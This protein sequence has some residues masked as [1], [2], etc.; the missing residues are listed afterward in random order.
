MV[1]GSSRTLRCSPN[2]DFCR[3]TRGGCPARNVTD[4]NGIGAD[5]GTLADMNGAK[6]FCPRTD[7]D[8]PIDNRRSALT[9]RSNGHL[10]E[11]QTIYSY[12]SIRVNDNA[13]RM[14]D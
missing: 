6:D 11:D 4:D 9:S 10:L 3:D 1:I 8:M 12:A 14:R 5:R 2:I 7:V 13:I